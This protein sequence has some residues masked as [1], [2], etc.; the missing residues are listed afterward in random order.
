MPF[1]NIP[2]KSIQA[3]IVDIQGIETM[4]WYDPNSFPVFP[5]NPQP[6]PVPKDFRWKITMNIV[7][8]QQSSYLTRSPGFYNGQDVTVGQWIGNVVTGQAWQIIRIDSKTNDQIVLIIQDVYRYNTFRDPFREGNGGPAFGTYLIFNLSDAGLPQI[9]PV[10]EGITSSSFT[11]NIQSRFEYINLQY[12][13]P[14]FAEGNTFQIGDVIAADPANNSFT[15]SD[16]AH[17]TVI[18]RV[19]SISDTIPG[20]FTVKPVQKVVDNLDYL[21][22]D[23]GDTLYV[24]ITNPGEI[25]IEPGGSTVY[26]KLRN[27]TSSRTTSTLPGPTSPG[28]V[29]QLNSVD[30]TVNGSGTAND[31]INAVNLETANTGVNAVSALL[32]STVTTAGNLL[33]PTYGEVVLF[34]ASSPAAAT[35]NGGEVTFNITSTTPGYESYAQAP[36]MAESINAANIPNIVASANGGLLTITNTAGGP[37]IIQNILPDTAGVPVAGNDSGT[38]LA[39]NTPASTLRQIVFTAVDARAINFL[40]VVGSPLADFG[41]TSVENGTK[42]AGLYIQEGLREGSTTVVLDLDQLDALSPMIGDQA[43]V[44]DSDDGQ[45]NNVGEWSMWIYD[46]TDWVQTSNQDS[47][48]TDAKSLEYTITMVETG[49]INIG[50]LSTGRR[51]TLIT[52]EVTEVFGGVG[53]T[54]SIGYQVNNPS[55]PPAVLDGLMPESQID[56]TVLGT[57]STVTDVLFGTDT[58]QGD[59]AIIANFVNGG[60]TLGSAQIIVSYV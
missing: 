15:L 57:Y 34:A 21:P 37:I 55:S 18:G 26:V 7:T 45:G 48:T 19:N 14:L 43:Y 3:D 54:L 27:N 59:V 29:F 44:I 10:P 36:Q 22:G 12:D 28:N 6:T 51:V 39:L 4:P 58:E 42:A 33:S 32:P 41:I 47:A 35:I 17:T 8:Q 1:L 40:D 5:G 46:G 16:A 23:V 49:V 56:L 20:W 30:I 2:L 38:G 11:Q 24:S 13:Y 25:T 50:K 53:P 9:D 31:L 60:S 52:V